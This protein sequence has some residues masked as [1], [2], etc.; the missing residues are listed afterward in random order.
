MS[1]PIILA[2]SSVYRRQI[3]ERLGL[4]FSCRSP[5]IDETHRTAESAEAMVERLSIEKANA[6]A[7]TVS[8]GLVIGSD[9]VS[10]QNGEI[11]GK[12]LDHDDAVK[13]LQRAS[14]SEATLYS[15]VAVVN[16]ASGKVQSKVVKVEVIC[17]ALNDQEI[18][19]YL[20]ADKPYNCCGSLKVEGLGI[21][22]L[23]RISSDDPNAISGLPVIALLGML[24]DEGITLP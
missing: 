7:K 19:R 10:E 24:R 21:A 6:I 2:S 8:T 23:E 1:I 13:Q 17:R 15:G 20:A 18:E 4:E 16:A 12:P 5:E 3:L 14:G 11:L 9:Q 22:L